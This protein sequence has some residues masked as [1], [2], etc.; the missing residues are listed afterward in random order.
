[1]SGHPFN[2]PDRDEEA[3]SYFDLYHPGLD[4]KRVEENILRTVFRIVVQQSEGRLDAKYAPGPFHSSEESR[5]A[6]ANLRREH[7]ELTG[8][9]LECGKSECF[10][11]IRALEYLQRPRPSESQIIAQ[12]AVYDATVESWSQEFRGNSAVLLF[13]VLKGYLSNSATFYY[14]R[15]TSFVQSS[16]TGKSRTIDELAKRIV[17]IP[18]NLAEDEVDS[19]RYPPADSKVFRTWFRLGSR[20]TSREH[21]QAFL[22]GLLSVTK[23]RLAE[24]QETEHNIMSIEDLKFISGEEVDSVH[25]AIV[26]RLSS[27]A[28]KFRCKMAETTPVKD[29][30]KGFTVQTYGDYRQSFYAEVMERADTVC[31]EY[32]P[33]ANAATSS[34][35]TR[36]HQKDA[37]LVK[38]GEDLQNFLNPIT[39]IRV[40]PLLVLCFDDSSALL[41]E[42]TGLPR[43]CFSELR[44][45]LSSLAHIPFFS[46]FLSAGGNF[47]HLT[48]HW[49]AY[50]PQLNSFAPITETGFDE[51]ANRVPNDGTWPLRRLA[52]THHIA[53]LGRAVFPTYY[54]TIAADPDVQ[55]K[56]VE[57]A[58]N[59]LLAVDWTA[60]MPATLS[61]DQ[62]LACLAVRLD[63]NFVH[64]TN[65]AGQE[66]ERTLV[67]HH[68]RLCVDGPPGSGRT[69][70][71]SASEP[72]LADAA[73]S[74]MD[75]WDAAA[76]LLEH[77][78]N[79]CLD[80][81]DRGELITQLL[82]LLARDAGL[83][84]TAQQ[85]LRETHGIHHTSKDPKTDGER[86]IISV[87]G[88][89]DNLLSKTVSD[90]YPSKFHTDSDRL[91][92]LGEAYEDAAIWFNHFVR[93]HDYQMIGQKHLWRLLARGAA[94]VCANNQRGV[95][96]VIPVLFH[97]ALCE[98]NVSAILIQ[99]K[100][101]R[102]FTDS[103]RTS[104]FDNMDPFDVG[105]YARE[106][107]E[108]LPIIRMVFALASEKARIACNDRPLD[109]FPARKRG[110]QKFTAY[111][112][113]CAG[114]T[115]ETFKVVTVESALSYQSLLLRSRSLVNPYTPGA[116]ESDTKDPRGLARRRMH[117][118]VTM[119][120]EHFRNYVTEE[121]RNKF[122]SI[123]L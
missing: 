52:S 46:V 13:D 109:P 76:A 60:G 19:I 91:Q 39:D 92:T 80:V 14:G 75:G 79:S 16:G 36:L 28:R 83:K 122:R 99:V 34:S 3:N 12:R 22:Y 18:M 30:F 8:L 77:V 102:S 110:L 68:L 49:Q 40:G 37:A 104:L 65:W 87:V 54:D 106:V 94:V 115:N 123:S 108:P 35:S 105:L 119:Q 113:W 82:V 107:E 11:K 73:F 101:D 116:H 62:K 42:R 70:T 9:L 100:N 90:K 95:D 7:P 53:H 86:R 121:A 4:S 71:I 96:I 66:K 58:R 56:I 31:T 45:A 29:D 59:K 112:I 64:A 43:T 84:A 23:D 25:D 81:G 27:L 93:V 24:I 1:M 47:H 2:I 51:F 69:E 97:D 114:V 20:G 88:F 78:E 118:G 85:A 111:D 74:S 38:A 17:V 15:Y 44:D 98:K 117:P 50:L 26:N 103:A 120:D 89:L 6:W 21:Y 32:L 67:R 63:I 57:F 41:N 33:G 55:T 61:S 10:D 5:V 48:P 72:L